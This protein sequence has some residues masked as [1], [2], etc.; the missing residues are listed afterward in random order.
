[1]KTA[2][3]KNRKSGVR[4][5]VTGGAGFIGSHVALALLRAG[6]K[7]L[8]IDDLSHG[9]ER[10]IPHGAIFERRGITRHDLTGIFRKWKPF[11]VCHHAAQISVRQSVADPTYD[12]NVNILGSVKLLELARYHGIEYFLFA[13]TGGALYGDQLHF[14]ATEDHPTYPVSPYGISK[15]AGEKYLYFYRK[16]YSLK[17]VSLRY[18]NVYGPRQDPLGEAG[19]V[20]I[21]CRKLLDGRAPTINGDGKQTRDYVYVEDVARANVLAMR[22]L[23]QG[24]INICTGIETDVNRLAQKIARIAGSK[25]K[26][27]HGPPMPGEQRRSV[28]SPRLASSALGWKPLV[29]L[30]EG[31]RKTWEY[32]NPENPG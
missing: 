8:I 7:V 1:M 16:Q 5:I 21:F 32:F 4:V 2:R 19:V 9:M 12:L 30:D 29:S 31:L 22:V 27:R 26:F 14:P 15:L 3:A 18:S 10:N 20:A 13:S 6:H 17:G 24:E 28:L 25:A 23:A 11:A